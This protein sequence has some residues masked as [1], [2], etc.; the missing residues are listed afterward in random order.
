MWSTYLLLKDAKYLPSCVLNRA[1]HDS[2]SLELASR[3][4]SSSLLEGKKNQIDQ[5]K[6]YTQGSSP[7][8][9]VMGGGSCYK[10]PEFKSR[11]QI[12]DGHFLHLFFVKIVM[13]VYKDENK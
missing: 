6:F 11:N 8:L 5:Q 12:L 1:D 2:G 10:G 7:G 3:L 13:C 4:K 9:V